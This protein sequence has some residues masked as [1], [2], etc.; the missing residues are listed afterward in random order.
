MLICNPAQI[1]VAM[2][3]VHSTTHL[4]HLLPWLRD[5]RFWPVKQTEKMAVMQPETKN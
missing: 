3:R 5:D 4:V 2:G 1:T